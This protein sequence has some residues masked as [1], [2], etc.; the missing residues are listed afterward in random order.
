MADGARERGKARRREAILRAAYTL[1]AE[2]GFEVATIADIAEKAEVSPR[3]VTLY[4]PSKLD[5]ATS[6]LAEFTEQLS[7]ALDEREPGVT[8]LEALERFLRQDLGGGTEP[9]ELDVLFDRMLERNPQLRAVTNSRL[10]EAIQEGA[11][12]F[13]AERGSDPD[14]FGPRIVAAAAAAVVSEVYLHPSEENFETAMAF[15]A[16]GISALPD[17]RRS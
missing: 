10:A 5:L 9:A 12:V 4:F 13:A 2:R 6:Q 11:R 1:F 8:T 14:A 16:G 15:L 17:G 7:A 3:T